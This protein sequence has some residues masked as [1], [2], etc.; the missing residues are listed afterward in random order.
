MFNCGISVN[1]I[2]FICFNANSQHYYVLGVYATRIDDLSVFYFDLRTS[3]ANHVTWGMC[4]CVLKDVRL[5][6]V[7]VV[8]M[9]CMMKGREK[10]KPG[11]DT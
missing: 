2:N 10:V 3:W 1:I 11:A 9:C 8:Q 7:Y 4:I 5:G 6:R